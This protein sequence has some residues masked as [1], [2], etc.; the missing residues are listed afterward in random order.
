M[1][2]DERLNRIDE[3]VDQRV[4]LTLHH[5][6]QSYE[7]SASTK[8][9]LAK[10]VRDDITKMIVCV[11]AEGLIESAEAKCAAA[12]THAQEMKQIEEE[13]KKDL[14]FKEVKAFYVRKAELPF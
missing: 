10:D 7:I 2:R 13:M 5:I 8:T 6:M 1:S 3:D 11:L 9:R 4:G 14:C 12:C